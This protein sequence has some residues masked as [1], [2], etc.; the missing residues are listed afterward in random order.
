MNCF[1]L[2]KYYSPRLDVFHKRE[3]DMI[4]RDNNNKFSVGIFKFYHV[5]IDLAV[6]L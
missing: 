2:R 1:M 3:L 5:N 6:N 4:T